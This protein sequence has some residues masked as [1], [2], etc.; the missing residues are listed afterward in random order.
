MIEHNNGSNP[1]AGLLPRNS[2][3]N[4]SGALTLLTSGN[5]ASSPLA[6]LVQDK[7]ELHSNP[8]A[9]ETPNTTAN[10]AK[11]KGKAKTEGKGK[12]KGKQVRKNKPPRVKGALPRNKK[13]MFDDLKQLQAQV[14]EAA[15]AKTEAAKTVATET[16]KKTVAPQA[17]PAAT[18]PPVGNAAQQSGANRAARRREEKSLRKA[19]E[20]A[21]KQQTSTMPKGK[22]G[23]STVDSE[24]KAIR[25]ALGKGVSIET[26]A[27]APAPAN[28][29]S[30]ATASTEAAKTAAT[31]AP[32]KPVVAQPTPAATGSAEAAK[33]AATET[34]KKPIAAKPTPVATGKQ[35]APWPPLA[36]TC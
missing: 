1:T 15:K 28:V 3:N 25:R 22:G 33:T 26:L 23:L 19:A 17:Q 8:A 18:E 20:R 30:A 32:K 10:G 21:K 35:F 24:A 2:R 14:D 36:T 4:F 7:V 11:S 6:P 5:K 9:T 27:E 16:P 13:E 12:A 31:E 29:S 34:P